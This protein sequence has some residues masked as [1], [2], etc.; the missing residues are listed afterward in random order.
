MSSIRERIKQDIDVY[1]E[2]KQAE[3]NTGIT[4][5]INQIELTKDKVKATIEA[6]YITKSDEID[7]KIKLNNKRIKD[8]LATTNADMKKNIEDF[9]KEIT[10]QRDLNADIT[11]SVIENIEEKM[12]QKISEYIEN[13]SATTTRIQQ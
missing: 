8:I 10:N 7:T 13:N 3:I 9:N 1:Y 5:A 2:Q 12:D 11:N 6:E 4:V